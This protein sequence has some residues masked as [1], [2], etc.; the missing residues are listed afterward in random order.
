MSKVQTPEA[1]DGSYG[2]QPSCR[3][4]EVYD[5]TKRAHR[6]TPQMFRL[7][8]Q[9]SLPLRSEV[10]A[11]AGYSC[12]LPGV[13]QQCSLPAHKNAGNSKLGRS[14]SRSYKVQNSLHVQEGRGNEKRQHRL[15]QASARSCQQILGFRCIPLRWPCVR[16]TFTMLNYA[17]FLYQVAAKAG[18]CHRASAMRLS[19]LMSTSK[20]SCFGRK[21]LDRPRNDSRDLDPM[22]F[23][24]E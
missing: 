5:V 19:S 8:F 18:Q 16:Q 23:I 3:R 2:F 20:V 9:S 21:I 11:L 6:K 17:V 12:D 10:P 24:T 7:E 13:G 15:L 22:E 4:G 1:V 14:I